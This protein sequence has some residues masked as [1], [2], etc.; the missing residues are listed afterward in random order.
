MP[1][2][3]IISAIVIVVLALAGVSYMFFFRAP[4][5]V[6][7]PA[8]KTSVHVYKNNTADITHIRVKAFYAVP[9]NKAVNIDPSWKDELSS[10]LADAAQF[11]AL[12]FRG[13]SELSYD[14][15]PE[16]VMLQHDDV[17]YDTTSTNDGN[18]HALVNVGEEIESRIFKSG[19]DLYDPAF[20]AVK[21]GEYTV[22][23]ILYEGVG[24]SGGVIY[25]TPLTDLGDIAKKLDLPESI[26]YVVNIDSASGFFILNRDYLV[27]DSLKIS[28]TSIF[29]HE[30]AHTIGLPDLFNANNAPYSN[31]IMGIGREKPIENTYIGK[32]FLSAMGVP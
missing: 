2:K 23:A 16:P 13:L 4:R 31:D 27:K 1:K 18:P 19:G 29:Y 10:A 11:H 8:A 5:V 30:F 25:D 15:Y 28:G 9:Q 26:I 20:A 7:A 22:W 14:I 6:P 17:T 21:P 24:A 12:Q 3:Y 32:D